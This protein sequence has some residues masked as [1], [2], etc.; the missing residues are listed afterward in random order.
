VARQCGECRACCITL[1]FR[2][3]PGEATFEKPANTPCVHL[4][5][6]G[7][8]IYP[9]RP[10]ACSRFECAWLA[11]PNLPEEMRPDRCGVLFCTNDDPLLAGRYAVFGYELRPG[12]LDEPLPE[13]LIGEV[14][15]EMTVVLVRHDGRTEILSADAEI[16]QA[17]NR[18]GSET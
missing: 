2:A 4:V 16:E 11:A 1:G 3:I 6:I 14:S 13:W 18:T 9:S 12:A 17:L 7:C 8:G 5:Q 10:P 15:G